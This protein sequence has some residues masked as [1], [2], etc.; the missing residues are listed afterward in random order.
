M[1][2]DALG[3]ES[4]KVPKLQIHDLLAVLVGD[5]SGYLQIHDQYSSGETRLQIHDLRLNY[6]LQI[7]AVYD[8]KFYS[9]R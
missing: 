4:I 8:P 6:P 1:I 7:L 9:Q 2:F 5:R 3:A